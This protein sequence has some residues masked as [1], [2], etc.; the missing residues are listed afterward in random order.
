MSTWIVLADAGRARIFATSPRRPLRLV[1]RFAHAKSRL[2]GAA[3]TADRPGR[4]RLAGG[5]RAA[6][7]RHTPA[8]EVEAEHFA[9][10][11]VQFLRHAHGTRFSELA[12]VAPPHFLGILRRT[13]G[14]DLR[15]MIVAAAPEDLTELEERLLPSHL[16][17]LLLKI[18]RAGAEREQW[19]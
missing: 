19:R 6:V 11:L 18:Q 1:R 13:L 8:K 2:K 14:P 10:E 4:V 17:D 3:V 12:L 15:R 16:H 5:R 7:D 9:H